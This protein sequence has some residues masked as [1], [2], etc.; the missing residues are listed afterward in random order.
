VSGED[1]IASEGEMEYLVWMFSSRRSMSVRITRSDREN[2]FAVGS[3]GMNL[4]ASG[5]ATT[6][7][8]NMKSKQ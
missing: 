4:P 7:E 2:G 1:V 5:T 8:A 3:V 6:L